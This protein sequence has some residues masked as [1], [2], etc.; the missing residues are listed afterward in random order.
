MLVSEGTIRTYVYIDGFNL[1]YGA[2]KG[3]P[4]R[5]LNPVALAAQLVPAS[6]TISKVK[7]FS[8]RVSGAADP[9]SPRRQQA[10]IS[11]LATLPEVQT[12]FG[13]F[14]SKAVWR[15]ITNF[16]V[17]AA[18]INSANPV[19]LPQGT[20]DVVGGSLKGVQHLV[21]DTYPP[22]QAQRGRVPAPL[23]DALIVQVHSM[24]EKGSDVN[25]GAHLLNDAWKQMFDAAIVI[26]N[27]TDLVTPIRMVAVE[28]QKPVFVVCPGRWQM[29]PGLAQ[30]AT[31]KRHIHRSMLSTAQFPDTIPGT[32]VRKPVNW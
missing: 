27:D 13:R 4:F 18:T 28:R 24:E 9:S 10:Y 26:S 8:A 23:S 17:A 3:T 1:Y 22:R 19:T 25:L 21:V 16:P 31:Y 20:H 32:T 11:A 6:H 14:L 30:V 29:A 7:Y 2:L 12:Y 5:W 15:P